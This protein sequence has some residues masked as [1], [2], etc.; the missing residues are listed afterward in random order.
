M[1]LLIVIL[2]AWLAAVVTALLLCIMARRGDEKVARAESAPGTEL[3]IAAPSQRQL[4][5]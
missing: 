3:P 5:G 4:A 1:S 2:V